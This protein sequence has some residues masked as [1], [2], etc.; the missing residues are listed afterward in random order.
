MSVMAKLLILFLL[1]AISPSR[2]F[3]GLHLHPELLK[4]TVTIRIGN[5]YMDYSP[6][7][8]FMIREEADISVIP[9]TGIL[10]SN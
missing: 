7:H 6:Y 9:S 8:T 1:L 5:D 4:T 3:D 10:D 2:S